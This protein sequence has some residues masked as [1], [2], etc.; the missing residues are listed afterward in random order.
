MNDDPYP[1]TH[2]HGDY[3]RKDISVSAVVY[4]LSGRTIHIL[5]VVASPLTFKTNRD[6]AA[7][8]S[9]VEKHLC[10][11][12]ATVVYAPWSKA[13][14][15]PHLDVVEHDLKVGKVTSV[16][17]WKLLTLDTGTSC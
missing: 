13:Y 15:E 7:Q 2:G 17:R 16:K 4:F 14:L 9:S 8:M 1:A 3:E 11:R 12:P 5:P 6:F 10:G